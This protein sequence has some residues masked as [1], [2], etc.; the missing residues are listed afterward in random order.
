MGINFY[1]PYE[2][3]IRGAAKDLL[4][5]E[6][7]ASFYQ[8]QYNV[9]GLVPLAYDGGIYGA[10]DSL[11][12]QVLFYRKDILEGLELPVPK[13]W[14]D[15]K[16]MMPTLLRYSMNFSTSLATGSSFKT[17]NMTGPFIYQ[18]GG[19]FYSPDGTS[20]AFNNGA[21][22]EGL[23]Q[24]TE[25]FR[26]YSLTESNA[27]FFNSFRYGETPLGVGNFS[28]YVQLMTAAPELDGKWGI[29]LIPG[30]LQE[31]GSVAYYQAADS[32]A[33]MIFD[34]TDKPD[35]AW[36]FLKWWLS[37]ETQ[38]EFSNRLESTYGPAYR[39]NTANLKAFAQ[40]PYP[41]EDKQIIL[42]QISYQKETGRHPAGYMVEREVS[43]IWNQVVVNG[44]GLTESIDRAVI[45]SNREIIRKL[46]EFGFMDENGNLIKPYLRLNGT[47]IG[48]VSRKATGY[49]ADQMTEN[50]YSKKIE[51]TKDDVLTL[52]AP[53]DD[54]FGWVDYVRLNAVDPPTSARTESTE[55]ATI[56]TEPVDTPSG[57]DTNSMMPVVYWIIG[58]F[59]FAAV[60]CGVIIL[61]RRKN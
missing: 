57:S 33:S 32:T 45:A 26:V 5:Y 41:E 61:V 40:L 52:V 29:A 38:A 10:V 55:E 1:T 54:T 16:D 27:N 34:N 22:Q 60:L 15:V 24:M 50:R 8:S 6:D 31:D 11:N 4:E 18:N 35:E 30:E 51:L 25:L 9:A 2:L 59:A 17:F 53:D 13:T 49:G 44:E 28:T 42:E 47:S 56:A 21:G 46:Q 37:S 58:V 3:A 36:D 43:N 39:W 14:D 7:F 12:Y 19:D 20:V 23:L 48:S